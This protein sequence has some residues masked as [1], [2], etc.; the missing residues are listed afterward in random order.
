MKSVELILIRERHAREQIETSVQIGS[1][2]FTSPLRDHPAVGSP[3]SS[4]PNRADMGAFS[5][6]LAVPVVPAP[7]QSRAT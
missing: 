6:S 1:F 7:T 4:W 2:R 5:G 3:M